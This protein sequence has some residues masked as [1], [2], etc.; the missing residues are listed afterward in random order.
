MV[1]KK[2]I[3]GAS[4]PTPWTKG[5]IIFFTVV[6]MWDMKVTLSPKSS[7]STWDCGHTHAQSMNLEETVMRNKN[8]NKKN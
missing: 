5:I 7:F 1:D 8:S 3:E 4:I 2:V 6:V